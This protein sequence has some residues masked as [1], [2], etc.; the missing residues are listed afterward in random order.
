MVGGRTLWY[1]RDLPVQKRVVT[2]VSG[3]PDGWPPNLKVVARVFRHAADRLEGNAAEVR[4]HLLGFNAPAAD[5]V[6]DELA[7]M[8]QQAAADA[9]DLNDM[10]RWLEHRSH[11]LYDEQQAYNVAQAKV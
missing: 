9:A 11:T 8:Q 6:R 4:G 10:A 3:R 2:A 5:R 7:R 1:P